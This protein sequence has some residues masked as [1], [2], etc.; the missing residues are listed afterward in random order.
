MGSSL[1]V[2]GYVLCT[3]AHIP[4]R[5]PLCPVRDSHGKSHLC[6]GLGEEETGCGASTQA[7][8]HLLQELYPSHLFLARCKRIFILVNLARTFSKLN[9]KTSRQKHPW[10]CSV[11]E[12]LSSMGETLISLHNTTRYKLKAEALRL[13]AAASSLKTNLHFFFLIRAIEAKLV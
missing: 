12:Y 3:S 5:Y 1:W 7:P 4:S 10:C 11:L 2:P 9:K 13:L 8:P 6:M